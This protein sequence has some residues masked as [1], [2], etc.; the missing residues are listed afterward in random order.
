MLDEERRDS[1]SM[2]TRLRSSGRDIAGV[3]ERR[4]VPWPS[5]SRSRRLDSASLGR[6]LRRS[7]ESRLLESRLL[8]SRLLESRLLESRL[9][10]SRRASPVRSSLPGS[11]S[12][13]GLVRS[14]RERQLAS[15]S[16]RPQSKSEATLRS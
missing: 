6:S 8:E 9:L 2:D 13:P 7:R 16:S 11:A 1:P 5:L 12:P 3:S 14:K 10:E 4:E 15:T